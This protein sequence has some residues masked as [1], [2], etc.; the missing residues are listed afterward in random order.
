MDLFS[1]LSKTCWVV[2]GNDIF[3]FSDNGSLSG[4]INGGLGSNTLDYSA[5]TAGAISVDLEAATATGIGGIFSNI[6][7]LVGS[8]ASDSLILPDGGSSVLITSDDS[9]TVDGSFTFS[10]IETINGGDGDDSIAFEGTATLSG[11]LNGGLGTDT[12]DFSTYGS[13]VTVNLSTGT[14]DMIG[15]L[16]SGIENLIGSDNAD[17]LTGS[18][19]ANQIEGGQGG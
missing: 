16:V 13:G 12:L 2:K 8:A 17:D 15:G 6:Q 1:V 19:E 9:G 5:Y 7:V 10:D 4:W 18:N 11:S 14:A 3:A